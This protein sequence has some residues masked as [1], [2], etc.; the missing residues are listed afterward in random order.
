MVDAAHGQYVLEIALPWTSMASGRSSIPPRAGET[1]RANFY[2]FRDGQRDSLAWSPLLGRGNFHF[3]GR[4]G[5]LV[6]DAAR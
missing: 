3:S 6:F 4:F 5:R 1:W 2:S